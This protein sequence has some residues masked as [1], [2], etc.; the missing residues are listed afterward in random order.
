MSLTDQQI[1][2]IAQRVLQQLQN[3]ATPAPPRAA[4]LSH[5]GREGRQLPAPPQGGHDGIYPDIDSAVAAAKH[6]F[7]RFS[8]MTL[9]ERKKLIDAIRQVSLDNAEL[10]ARMAHEET[11][12]GRAEDKIKKNVLVAEKSPGPEILEPRA[13]T[14]DHGLTLTEWAPYGVVAAITPSTNPTSTIINNS[15]GILS[16]GNAVVFNVHPGAKHVSNFVI[17]AI[18]RTIVAAGGPHDLLTAAAEP[19]I[20]SAQ[21]LMRHPGVRL[22]VVTGGPGVVKEAMTS[23]KRAICGGPGNPP[24]VVDETADLEKAGRDIVFGASFDNNIICVDEKEAFIVDSVF[25]Q[26]KSIMLAHGAVEVPSYRLAALEKVIFKEQR[27]P[28]KAAVTNKGWVGKD[29]GR[30]LKEIGINAPEARLALIE[31]PI[32]HPLI[33]T[34]QLMPVFPIA[35]VRSVDEGIELAVEAEHGF[36]HTASMFSRNIDALSR[37]AR[38]INTSIFV[39]NGPNLAG[40]GYK[41]EGSTSFTIASPTGEGLTD[42]ISFSRPRR[43]VMVDHFRIV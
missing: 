8:A 26:L 13:R 39:K 23:G 5:I 19:T 28:R 24:V 9:E 33:W 22:L 34:E 21:A 18:N 15:I 3:Q 30:I 12:L 37:M 38:L 17:Q 25:D 36:G 31:V 7:A 43:C 2:S 14:G 42:A 41:G 35:R 10:W 29:A 11:G 32:D 20:A 4:H 1:N 27:G 40:L 16:A 6:A